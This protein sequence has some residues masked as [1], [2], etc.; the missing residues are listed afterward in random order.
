MG[1]WSASSER[2]FECDEITLAPDRMVADDLTDC[3]YIFRRAANKRVRSSA[4]NPARN[5]DLRV[6]KERVTCAVNIR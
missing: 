1:G 6:G 5:R 3:L 2:R 4:R